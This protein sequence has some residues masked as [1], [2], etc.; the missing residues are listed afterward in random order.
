MESFCR[1][2]QLLFFLSILTLCS[3]HIYYNLYLIPCIPTCYKLQ[4]KDDYFVNSNPLGIYH[5]D[6]IASFTSFHIVCLFIFGG[7]YLQA[8]DS[9]TMYQFHCFYNDNC[10]YWLKKFKK[11]DILKK[12]IAY[13]RN[14]IIKQ[15]LC[16]ISLEKLNNKKNNEILLYCGHRFIKKHLLKYEKSLN[17]QI[18]NICPVCKKQYI[19][20]NKY[21]YNYNFYKYDTYFFNDAPIYKKIFW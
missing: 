9:S 8:F 21:K 13:R 10:L 17:N 1:T 20:S 16:A 7:L 5:L 12:E 4:S 14:L 11:Y 3:A 19:N 18:I 6:F 15:K 2:M